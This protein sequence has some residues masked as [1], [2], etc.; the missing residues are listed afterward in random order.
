MWQAIQSIPSPKQQR[1]PLPSL[2][3]LFFFYAS[4]G[5]VLQSA[6]YFKAQSVQFR[7]LIL[8]LKVKSFNNSANIYQILCS[9]SPLVGFV[10][11]SIFPKA[12]KVHEKIADF[13]Q[14]TFPP[15]SRLCKTISVT[16]CTY[17]TVVSAQLLIIRN[18]FLLI[19]SALVSS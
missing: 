3:S 14:I 10:G 1:R 8:I 17:S 2:L 4:V 7:C 15:Q 12:P 11:S 19:T 9:S 5:S 6:S 13:F 16:G 18:H